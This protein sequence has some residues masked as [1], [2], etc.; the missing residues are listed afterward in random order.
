MPPSPATRFSPRRELRAEN[1]KR[2]RSLESVIL[3]REKD[4]DLALFNEVQNKEKENFLLQSNDDFEDAFL[5]KLRHF[6]DHKGRITIPGRG[7]S[8]DLLNAEGDKNDYEWLITPPET[9][10]FP[11][12]DDETL[13]VNDAQRGR[14]R[15]QPVS[16]SS[17]S[18][19]ERSYRSNRGSASPHRLSLSPQSGNSISQSRSRPSSEPQ[20]SPPPRLKHPASVR[21]PS[22]PPSKPSAP[23]V[24]SSSPNPGRMG[25]GSAAPLRMTGNSP[26]KTSRGNSASPKIRAW[27]SNI[28]GFSSEAP[29]NLRTSLADRPASYVR[30]SSPASRN[31]SRS[32]RESMS[33]TATSSVSSPYTPDRYMFSSHSKGS[34]ASSGDDDRESIKSIPITS[35]DHS[36]PRNVGAIPNNRALGCSKKPTKIVSSSAPKRSFDL[37][38][39][40]MDHRKGPQNM[41]RPLLSSVPGSTFYAGKASASH[42]SMISRNSSITTSSNASS[43]QG[44]S[45]AHDTEESEQNQ[46]DVTSECVMEQYPEVHD[47]I[48]VFDQVDALNEGVGQ[49]IYKGSPKSQ[50][51]EFVVNSVDNSQFVVDESCSQL[52]TTIDV[53]TSAVVLDGKG[54]YF[55]AD[56]LEDLAICS[57]CGQKL[58]STEMLMEGEQKF[59]PECRS[60]E[61]P[62]TLN[63]LPMVMMAGENALGDSVKILQHGSFEALECSA[64]IS[65]P[66][67]VISVGEARNDHHDEISNEGQHCSVNFSLDN[68][69]EL[70][71][72]EEVELNTKKQEMGLPTDGDTGHQQSEHE[73]VDPNLEVNVSEGAGISVLFKRSSSGK[74]HIVQ[75]KSFSATNI[76]FDCFSR[77]TDRIDSMRSSFGHGS[78]SVSSSVDLGSSRQIET[79]I[80]R[81][82]SSS[83]SDIE[84]YRYEMPMKHKR[85]TSSLSGASS[86]AL[87]VLSVTANSHEDSFE[88]VS[89]NEEKDFR[90]PTCTDPREQSLPSEF[91]ENESTSA[92]VES[93]KNFIINSEFS[94]HV[95]NIHPGD[96]PSVSV[97]D[98]EE[99]PSNEDG[100]NVSKNSSNPMYSE[101]SSTLP[102]SYTQ[103]ED[104]MPNIYADWVDVGELP[105]RSS[106]DAISE[107]E[108]KNGDTGSP[109]SQSDIDSTD[110]KS[111][112]NELQDS[113]VLAAS[114]NII[115]A[116]VKNSYPS[117]HACDILEESTVML[118]N[119]GGMQARS[120]TLEEATDTILFCSS[121]VHN[122]AYEAANI[123]IE[124][125]N[126]VPLVDLQPTVTFFGRANVDRRDIHSRAMG[127]RTTKSQKARLKKLETVKK[128]PPESNI[129]SDGKT[130]KDVTC[131]V[132]VPNTGDSTRLPKLESKCN[133]TIM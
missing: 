121:I 125:E 94:G 12:L 101:A 44:T 19:M 34:V 10:L 75:S 106:L 60:L 66:L 112:I 97:S 130:D 8:S 20:L 124:K 96:T 73:R 74:G 119:R 108:I 93:N 16:I 54:D 11:S 110:S 87:K 39:R 37:A 46:D 83:K 36:A 116:S 69:L 55:D 4:D 23:A 38:L 120:L 81:Q 29:P 111:Y 129:E 103:E 109:D 118:D 89:V 5:T 77:V 9:P 58:N 57:K 91:T 62:L 117:G 131:I 114:N 92:N 107:I 14:P 78:T 40:Q 65:E 102:K 122:L 76:N 70:S 123:A 86:H 115:T 3:S 43:D 51:D 71:D 32:G 47:E 13:P 90:E 22:P 31:G 15:S 98:F 24:R 27:Q 105:N 84:N 100:E 7:E 48:F 63:T 17:S 127:K 35:S 133:C 26:A 126:S 85:S 21:R 132:E 18:T 79:R 6:S 67:Q 64:L 30:G 53:A 56:D 52:D 88:V 1:H 113:S 28:P 33:P 45:G 95:M 50:Y 59:C 49:K 61:A 104:A 42:R 128:L 99:P 82:L 80:Q 41:F 25:T 72:V 68:S 2:G